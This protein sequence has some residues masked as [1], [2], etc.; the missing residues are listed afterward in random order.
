M[1]RLGVVGVFPWNDVYWVITR[2]RILETD[3]CG[4]LPSWWISYRLCPAP[5]VGASPGTLP[6]RDGISGQD[7]W[8]EL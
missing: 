8:E 6:S 2:A 3:R 1:I 7:I 4:G 5:M